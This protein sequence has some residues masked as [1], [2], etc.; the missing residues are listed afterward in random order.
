MS[1]LLSDPIFTKEFTY[2]VHFHKVMQLRE[3]ALLFVGWY[4]DKHITVI[5]AHALLTTPK[6]ATTP[7]TTGTRLSSSSSEEQ[8][9][10]QEKEEEGGGS[11]VDL[12]YSFADEPV[13]S[14]AEL[15]RV[16]GDDDCHNNNNNNNNLIVSCSWYENGLKEWN[17]VTGQPTGTTY[18]PDTHPFSIETTSAGDGIVI[19]QKDGTILIASITTTSTDKKQ[20]RDFEVIRRLSGHSDYVAQNPH[21][22]Y[23]YSLCLFDDGSF[24]TALGSEIKWWIPTTAT[25]SLLTSSTVEWIC[26]DY[27]GHTSDVN[28]VIQL[29]RQGQENG[30][31]RIASCAEDGTIRVWTLESPSSPSSTSASASPSSQGHYDRV[32]GFPELDAVNTIVEPYFGATNSEDSNVK[33]VSASN[34]KTIRLWDM[35]TGAG[36][37]IIEALDYC[38]FMLLTGSSCSTSL[39]GFC[40]SEYGGVAFELRKLIR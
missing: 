33:I 17:Y 21:R 38:D 19:I 31:R 9:S 15:S 24:V 4:R 35:E 23:K 39:I 16:G 29:R 36:I 8:K 26:R 3:G 7:T 40:C 6:R 1:Y 18:L 37:I 22:Q 34:D 27:V 25:S 20:Q 32:V 14:V 28:Q 12:S 5:P 10:Q 30:R 11:V 13:V 2:N